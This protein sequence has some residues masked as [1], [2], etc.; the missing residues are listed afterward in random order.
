MHVPTCRT[1]SVACE[2]PN[3]MRDEDGR[4]PRRSERPN[5]RPSGES[6]PARAAPRH[7]RS[8]VTT[9]HDVKTVWRTDEVLDCAPQGVNQSS[10]MLGRLA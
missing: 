3:G 7:T 1:L 5:G 6:R 2:C 10:N 4:A 8:E 9:K